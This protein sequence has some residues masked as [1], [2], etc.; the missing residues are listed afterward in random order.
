MYGV[1][2]T[3]KMI[4]AVKKANSREIEIDGIRYVSTAEASRQLGINGTTIGYRLDSENFPT[5]IRIKGR[6][7][8]ND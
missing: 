3:K 7:M 1:P 6:K 8:P 2:K 4:D 5:Y